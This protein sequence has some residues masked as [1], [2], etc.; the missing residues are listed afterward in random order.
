MWIGNTLSIILRPRRGDSWWQRV[1]ARIAH[2]VLRGT[3]ATLVLLHI[4]RIND[5]VHRVISERGEVLWK[6]AARRGIQMR[7]Y[8]ALGKP[9]DAYRARVNGTDIV[10]TAIPRPIVSASGSEWWLDDKWIL[11]E[12]LQAAGVPVARGGICTD[13]R[14]AERIFDTLTKPLVVKPRLGSRGRHTTTHISTIEELR[15]AFA[16]ATQL[17]R[18]VVIEEHLTGAVYRGTAVGGRL[19]GVLA[20]EPPRVCGDG[21]HTIE[22]L[23]QTKNASRHDKVSPVVLG[24]QHRGF[25][26]RT[27]RTLASIPARDEV[28]DLIEKIGVS[29]GGHSAEVTTITHPGIQKILEHAAAVVDDPIIGFDFII[30]DITRAPVNQQWG[31]IECNSMPFINLHHDPV[32]G[33]PVNV[34][35][36]VW[37]YVE[38]HREDF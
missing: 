21:I 22:E 30:P 17:C 32:E 18:W 26:A 13:L 6:E 15:A 1:S 27:G 38:R 10:F 3:L 4:V 19:S 14:E 34:A 24:P 5:D 28:V 20:G 29:Y 16:C 36:D 12:R 23:V 33:I 9:T 11:K 8:I 31:I 25:L 37:D 7:S 35:K 2:L